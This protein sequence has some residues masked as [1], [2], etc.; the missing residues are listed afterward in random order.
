VLAPW[1]LDRAGLAYT[2]NGFA[3]SL[4]AASK[5]AAKG[6][7]L[8]HGVAT[9]ALI[10]AAS[11]ATA[12]QVILKPEWE[13]G[14]LGLDAASVMAATAIRAALAARENRHGGHFFAEAYIPGREF[15]VALLAERGGVRVLPIQETLFVDW[16]AARPRIVDFDAKWAPESLPYRNTP[17][18]FGIEQ[19][20]PQLA[21]QLRALA[22]DVWAAFALRG[23]A[24][25]DLRV[26]ASG[27]P[28]VIDVNPNPGLG[29]DAGFVA[30]AAAA[31]I[32]ADALFVQ[33][34]DAALPAAQAA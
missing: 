23:Y 6:V 15:N 1:F 27:A 4:A 9:P 11:G 29:P 33:L 17:R 31:G 7:L 8:A 20:E 34:V 16:P 32:E 19:S 3:A 12:G 18:R 2:G 14:S 25:V 28:W 22:R 21:A 13:H 5:L 10:D 26:D 24:R 30:A